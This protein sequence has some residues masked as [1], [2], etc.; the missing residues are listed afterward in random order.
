MVEK[1]N[2]S[3]RQPAGE[4]E[5]AH[6]RGDRQI[7]PDHSPENTS[8]DPHNPTGPVLPLEIAPRGQR[9]SKPVNSPGLDVDW[10]LA[11]QR[12]AGNRSLS[13]ILSPVEAVIQRGEGD[14]EET[15]TAEGTPAAGGTAAEAALIIEEQ[16]INTHADLT[17]LAAR[18]LENCVG[19]LSELEWNQEMH[20]R[21][22]E[23]I[24]ETRTELP[25][26][27]DHEEEPLNTQML[28]YVRRWYAEYEDF[29]GSRRNS[30]RIQ[31]RAEFRRLSEQI[32]ADARR[33]LARQG[34]LAEAL[35]S[36][37][38]R[39]DTGM[40][41]RIYS[42]SSTALDVGLGM[43]ELSR[44]LMDEIIPQLEA[45]FEMQPATRAVGILTTINRI[46]AAIST[47]NTLQG[48]HQPR[49]T[50]SGL[51]A[52]NDMASLFSS[53]GSLIPMLAPHIG[54]YANLYLVPMTE[55]ITDLAR[56]VI[57]GELHDLEVGAAAAGLSVTPSEETGGSPML[58]FM[59]SLRNA[60][61]PEEIP[62]PLPEAVGAYILDHR[63]QMNAG[64][65][66]EMPTHF[67][68]QLWRG[69]QLEPTQI[70]GWLYRSR[71][72]LW[73]MLY[74]SMAVPRPE[75]VRETP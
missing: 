59:I 6:A 28:S 27:Q 48:F 57:S 33:L 66:E 14:E 2:P 72:S 75:Q 41:E 23:W 22:G 16:P 3:H 68:W 49:G 29:Q 44:S 12:T 47:L 54:L 67:T 39:N 20:E 46:N 55:A 50:E 56:D 53:T 52:V 43:N 40:I 63:E 42:L 61:T 7:R 70:R 36:A 35:R 18:L 64:T 15:A 37:Y 24:E 17:D 5:N 51:A 60:G 31:A 19:F 65:P 8:A 32:R 26:W 30:E 69:R 38:R 13:N 10:A 34:E 1:A 62:W 71:T 9:L 74:G 21:A 11:V 73:G 45:G 58:R 25:N 4:T